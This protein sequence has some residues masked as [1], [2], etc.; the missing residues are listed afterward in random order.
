MV[1][2]V[3]GGVQPCR[4]GHLDSEDSWDLFRKKAFEH[5]QEPTDPTIVD[6][7]KEILAK[8]GGV[9]LTISMILGK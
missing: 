4:L 5:G 1:A 9:P 7:A 8:C 2:K 6:I 3:M